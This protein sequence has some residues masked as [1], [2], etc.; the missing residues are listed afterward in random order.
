[1]E[2]SSNC[3]G[4]KIDGLNAS[5]IGRCSEC[6]EGCGVDIMSSYCAKHNK[7][8]CKE[9]Q[10]DGEWY[11]GVPKEEGCGVEEVW[12]VAERVA[13]LRGYSKILEKRLKKHYSDKLSEQKQ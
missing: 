3:C 5:G 6:K 4:A 13:F 2:L 12:D 7:S 11:F 1:M 8:I 10:E 9:C